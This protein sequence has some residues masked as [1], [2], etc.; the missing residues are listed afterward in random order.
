MKNRMIDGSYFQ[1][2]QSGPFRYPG[3]S[4]R[5]FHSDSLHSL[6]L[7]IIFDHVYCKIEVIV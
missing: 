2:M 5:L 6:Q 7:K 1:L 3:N 4:K